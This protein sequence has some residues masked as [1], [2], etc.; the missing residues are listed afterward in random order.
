MS[1]ILPRLEYEATDARVTKLPDGST[2]FTFTVQNGAV[3]D[4]TVLMSC[5]ILERLLLQVR[6]RPTSEAGPSDLPSAG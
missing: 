4:V 1:S 3:A 2:A 5:E 6:H